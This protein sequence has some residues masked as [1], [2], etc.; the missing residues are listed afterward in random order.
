MQYLGEAMAHKGK[1]WEVA[2][3]ARLWSGQS[4]WP[5]YPPKVWI[6]D[7]DGWLGS[8]THPAVTNEIECVAQVWTGSHYF[9]WR[10]DDLTPG[11]DSTVVGLRLEIPGGSSNLLHIRASLT[12]DG[13]EQYNSGWTW[14]DPTTFAS[15]AFAADAGVM[16]SGWILKPSLIVHYVAKPY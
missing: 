5:N 15:F 8:A 9:W 1:L 11:F 3:F 10:S 4:S 6:F 14:D 13:D 16:K 7:C 12:V 2:Q